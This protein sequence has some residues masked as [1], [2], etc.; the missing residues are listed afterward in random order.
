MGSKDGRF[1]PEL[2]FNFYLFFYQNP[3]VGPIDFVQKY[4]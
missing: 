1:K 3:I 4:I 2:N